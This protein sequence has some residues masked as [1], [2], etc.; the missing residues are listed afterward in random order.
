MEEISRNFGEILGNIRKN[1]LDRNIVLF[2]SFVA[3]CAF[4]I[5]F[6]GLGLDSD[7]RQ[8]CGA[9]GIGSIFLVVIYFLVFGDS[10]EEK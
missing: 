10:E 9:V 7:I 2:N 8:R 5:S 3:V 6:L 4:F 1:S